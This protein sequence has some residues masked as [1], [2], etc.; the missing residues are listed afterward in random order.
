MAP[1]I[2]RVVD[3]REVAHRDVVREQ[4]VHAAQQPP[5]IDVAI[6]HAGHG[7]LPAR[8]HA[9]VG[10]PGAAHADRRAQRDAE[11]ALELSLHGRAAGLELPPEEAR[12]FVL[13][14]E[15]ELHAAVSAAGDPR[16]R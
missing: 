5:E 15:P 14:D 13:D 4:R 6:R 16:H 1:R 2:E 8:V 11:R 3:E 10:P 7:H 9:R 12:A